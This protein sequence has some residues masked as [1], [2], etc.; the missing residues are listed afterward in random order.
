MGLAAVIEEAIALQQNRR[1]NPRHQYPERLL[2]AFHSSLSIPRRRS[3]VEVEGC[4]L[5]VGGFSFYVSELPTTKLIVVALG[6]EKARIYVQAKIVRY[7]RIERDGKPIIMV[8]CEF[9]ER[10]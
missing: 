7:Q 5:S 6:R 1:A 2:I 3:F 10:L 9:T 4:D 8:G